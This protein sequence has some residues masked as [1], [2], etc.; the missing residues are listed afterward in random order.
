MGVP[1]QYLRV[2]DSKQDPEKKEEKRKKQKTISVAV[3]PEEKP[4]RFKGAA[5]FRM[6]LVCA[7]LAGKTIRI[8]D[9]RPFEESVGLQDFEASFLRLL[10]KVSNGCTIAINETGTSLK[11]QPGL[12]VGG[13]G[14]VHDC[15]PS[16]SI[17]YY[18]EA[19]VLLAPF[20]KNP[21]SLT[22]NGVTNEKQDLSV[23]IIRTMTLPLMKI[24]GL[25]VEPKLTVKKRGAPP[26]GGG[27]A[28]FTCPI[29][30]HLKP[31]NLTEEG[32]I[33]RIRGIAYTTKCSPQFAKRM[34]DPARGVLNY[35]PDV[36]IYSDH[37]KGKDSGLSGGYGMSLVAESTTGVYLSAD[38]T[39]AEGDLPEDL[40]KSTALALINEISQGGCVDS[41][42]QAMMLLL[43]ILCPED[44]SKIRLGKLTPYTIECLRLYKEIFG[45]T[46]KIVPDPSNTTL[47]LSCL[48]IG[49]KNYS[50]KT[51]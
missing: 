35:I 28:I 15:P 46:F 45:V 18:L 24:F 16:R 42:H 7:T 8:D 19:L 1:K 2:E 37:F 34:I 44:V 39:A 26:L 40:G 33:K 11:Y 27:Q 32:K 20:C 14:L 17:S 30:D 36:H 22:L 9:I 51:A 50:R 23:D 41:S 4:L 49:F 21:I 48:G 5:N 12:L 25:E 43:M 13:S 3:V 29:V 38:S 10:D 6:R 47:L 31:I